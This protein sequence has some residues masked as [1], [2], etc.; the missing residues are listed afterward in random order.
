MNGQ[1][2]S[3]TALLPEVNSVPTEYEACWAQDRSSPSSVQTTLKILPEI[4]TLFFG[5][6]VHSLDNISATLSRHQ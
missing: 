5:R 3:L 6:P 2:R 4:E 1:P